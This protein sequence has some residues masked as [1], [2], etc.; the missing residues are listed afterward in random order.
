[1]DGGDWWATV[2]WV[3]KSWTQLSAQLSAHA[4]NRDHSSLIPEE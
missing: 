1:M 3:A 4:C 2:Y